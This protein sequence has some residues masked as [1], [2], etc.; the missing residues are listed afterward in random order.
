MSDA[1]PPTIKDVA[2]RAGVHSSTVSRA[3]ANHPGIPAGT[4]NRI[5]TLADEMGYRINPLTAALM[6]SRRRRSGGSG[7]VAVANLGFLVPQHRVHAWRPRSW[8]YE[9]YRGAREQA[10]DMRYGL[11]A[12]WAEDGIANPTAFERML[13]NRGVQGLILAPEHEAPMPF[14]L[15]WDKFGVISLHYGASQIIPRFNQLVSNHFH[16]MLELC[17]R[18]RDFGY[19][20]VGLVLR[21]HPD[22]HFEYGRLLLGAFLAGVGESSQLASI[23]PL[24]QTEIDVDQIATWARRHR[25]DAIIQAGGGFSLEFDPP[26]MVRQLRHNGIPAA[27]GV[28]LVIMGHRP[29]F[30]LATVDEQ[31]DRLGAMAVRM[32]VESIQQNQRGVPAHPIVHQLDARLCD[33]DSLPR[34]TRKKKTPSRAGTA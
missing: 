8:I 33:G 13:R 10:H 26:A 5:R 21:D 17:R 12:Y 1:L 2:Q 32:L 29:E 22:T 30:N 28:G 19:R 18:C 15:D 34:L 25:V 23:P 3:L 14:D 6:K 11:D 7:E 27:A 4:R 20:R 31:T 16:S 24:S 9:V